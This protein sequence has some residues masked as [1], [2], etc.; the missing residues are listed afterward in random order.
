[1]ARKNGNGEGSRPRERA[2]GRW[3][4]RYWA[5]GKRRSVYGSTRKEAADK[6]AKAIVNNEEPRTTLTTPNITVREFFAQY[7]DAVRDTM[8]RR[9]LETYRDIARL[10][11]LPAFGNKK[12]KDLTREHVQQMYSQKR[13]A[14]LSAARVRRIHGVLS[15]V[16]NHAVRWRLLYHN[17]CKE[18]SPPSV[19][20]LEIRPLNREE[21][22]RFLAAAQG[23]RYHALYVLGLT[24]GARIGEL[25]GMFWSDLDLD[26]RVMCVQRALITGR[27]GQTFEPPKTPNSRR[28]VGLSQR[29]ID[30]LERHRE[31]QRGEG[32][33]F[34]GDSLVF[35]NTVGGPINPSHLLCRSFKPLL[36]KAGLPRTTFHAATRHT[37]CCLALQQGINVRTIS[38]AM[39]HS[40]VAFTLSKYASYIPNYSDTAVGL[41]EALGSSQPRQEPF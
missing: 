10:H 20:A 1:V 37:F 30:A 28:S 2:D 12:L 39:G 14:G 34:E 3:E 41:D 19:P 6:L 16:L 26:R 21:A 15:S 27:G 17:V 9:S 7:D 33:P 38:L 8:K 29:A 22:N 36:E 31:R 25:G 18:V 13:D 32:L 35:T 40:S 4:A 24:T 11:L 23:D 5:G